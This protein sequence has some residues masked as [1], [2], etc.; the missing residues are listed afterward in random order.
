MSGRL[1][2]GGIVLLIAGALAVLGSFLPW[3]TATMAFVGTISRNGIDG[4]GDGVIT[5]VLGIVIALIGIAR[6]ARSGNPRT[7]RI[8]A[9]LAALVLG[10][11]TW[12]DV[13]SINQRVS[14]LDSKV[15]IASLG[16]GIIV[17]GIAAVLAFIGALLA[18]AKPTAR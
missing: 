15:A 3:I 12:V 4:G 2:W 10:V 14:G 1:E 7:M 5:I 17:I 18:P 16:M 6:L 8:G 13:A 11:V 9:G